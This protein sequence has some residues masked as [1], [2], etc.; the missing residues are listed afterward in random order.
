MDLIVTPARATFHDPPKNPSKVFQ[1]PGVCKWIHGCSGH[2]KKPLNV[3]Y[4]MNK[5][6]IA[7]C[8]E[9][10]DVNKNTRWEIKNYKQQYYNHQCF[11][12]FLLPHHQLFHDQVLFSIVVQ[13]VPLLHL[14]LQIL[15]NLRVRK[16]QRSDG[17]SYS[18]VRKDK[19]MYVVLHKEVDHRKENGPNP[20][21]NGNQEGL[22]RVEPG[23]VTQWVHDGEIAL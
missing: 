18:S 14:V 17:N 10:D 23:L 7:I 15:Q 9:V 21:D 19:A 11:R 12:H 5:H 4:P 22:D 2:Y 1:S 3:P 8:A 16:D 6:T 20:H 13:V